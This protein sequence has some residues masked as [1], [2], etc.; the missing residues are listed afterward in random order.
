MS[1][2]RGKRLGSF[3]FYKNQIKS[4][5]NHCKGIFSGK[6][7]L[8]SFPILLVFFRGGA[9]GLGRIEKITILQ[10]TYSIIDIDRC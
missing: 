3:S 1:G 10:D 2:G 7:F 5:K 8:I 6:A 9:G 4:A